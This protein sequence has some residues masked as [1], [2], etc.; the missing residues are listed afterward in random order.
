VVATSLIAC[1]CSSNTDGR[2]TSGSAV[3][4]PADSIVLE[5]SVCFG[6]CPA[7]RLRISS[8]GHVLFEPRNPGRP[9][10]TPATAKVSDSAF[11]YLT[12]QAERAGFYGFPEN[13]QEDS[14]LC[15]RMATDH[16]SATITI[17]RSTEYKRVHDYTGCHGSDDP[18]AATRL[19]TLREFEALVDS[20]A[21]SARWTQPSGTR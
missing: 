5:R 11:S 21:G 15:R 1:A 20:V 3:S 17:H 9:G 14:T 2:A 16:P 6:S 13:I 4:T 18:A 12:S 8:I 19:R 7:Y 10:Q